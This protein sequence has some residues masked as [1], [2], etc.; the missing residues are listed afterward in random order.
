MSMTYK[1]GKGGKFVKPKLFCGPSR[2]K[3]SFQKEC[4]VN[5]II[6]RYKKTGHLEHARANPG[7][8]SDVSQI[9]DY[10]G[11]VRRLKFAQDS[12]DDLPSDLRTRFRNDPAELI[13]FVSDD[14]NRDEA[15]KLGLVAKPKKGAPDVS[16]PVPIVGVP[17]PPLVAKAEEPPAPSK[18]ASAD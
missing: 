1:P 7:V 4:D 5:V 12:F 13:A 11:M 16:L 10:P 9:E 14:D 2:V 15:V 6:A 8:F 17:V 18:A 3:E